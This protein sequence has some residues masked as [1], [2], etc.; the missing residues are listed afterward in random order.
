MGVASQQRTKA[1]PSRKGSFASALAVMWTPFL[2][3][4]SPLELA[5]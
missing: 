1:S 3:S 4:S 5:P 2:F